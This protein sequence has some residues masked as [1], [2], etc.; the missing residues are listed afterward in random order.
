MSVPLPVSSS[1][2]PQGHATLRPAG[3]AKSS[4]APAAARPHG[5]VRSGAA[6]AA[7]T[8]RAKSGFASVLDAVQQVDREGMA[9]QERPAAAT[10]PGRRASVDVDGDLQRRATDTHVPDASAN[11]TPWLLLAL[12]SGGGA[13]HESG[14]D[15]ADG[16]SGAH[17]TAL[18]EDVAPVEGI[19]AAAPV[20][21][22]PI[23]IASLAMTT[24]PAMLEINQTA[25]VVGSGAGSSQ[26][27]E[28]AVSPAVAAGTPSGHALAQGDT[29]GA[30]VPEGIDA[31]AG[32]MPAEDLAV[33]GEASEQQPPK[34]AVSTD[35]FGKEAPLI[36]ASHGQGD[37][38]R[39]N[40]GGEAGQ[41]GIERH[42]AAGETPAAATATPAA[43]RGAPE[44]ARVGTRSIS[45][46]AQWLH[47]AA[48]A[49][50]ASQV[51][52][53]ASFS[54][55]SQPSAVAAATPARTSEALLRLAQAG[56][57]A[58]SRSGAHPIV[59]YIPTAAGAPATPPADVPAP[60]PVPSLPA[61]VGEQVLNQ[62]VSSLR[63]QWKDGIGEAK[64]QLRPDA[65]GTVSVSLRV[66]AGAVT[67]VVRAE[68]AQVQ[69][70]V[71]QNQETLRQQMEA[72]GLHLGELVVTPD[73]QGQSPQHAP[74]EQRRRRPA[75]QASAPSTT[76]EM[77]L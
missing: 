67:A 15:A 51:A 68:S 30:A 17:E 1:A 58:F 12:G 20:D 9:G 21:G 26:A 52:E 72:A 29:A 39:A 61:A 57:G 28:E 42:V 35:A 16:E 55:D 32:G 48:P 70:W 6:P 19:A 64:L 69:E 41:P 46:A 47:Q 59:S 27:S 25:P 5:V 2:A 66:E 60:A 56:D 63:M 36:P 62:V 74:Q 65:L 77:L 34:P 13:W 71:V 37:G 33:A 22:G 14:C 50:L 43:G 24:V 53:P 11:Q 3:S 45:R 38:S 44:Q 75:R 4:A 73:D 76:F 31:P 49:A 23:P 18:V 54:L 8:A 7:R 10:V 40:R